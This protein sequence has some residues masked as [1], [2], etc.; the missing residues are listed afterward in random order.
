MLLGL[1]PTGHIGEGCI[2]LEKK[3]YLKILS[4]FL[5]LVSILLV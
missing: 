4:E 5:S 3:S 2:V 1:I